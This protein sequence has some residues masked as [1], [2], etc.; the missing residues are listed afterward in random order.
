MKIISAIGLE[1]EFDYKAY[2]EREISA[3]AKETQVLMVKN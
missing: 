1:I 2:A 3:L